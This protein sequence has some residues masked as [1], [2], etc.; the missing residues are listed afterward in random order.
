M[1]WLRIIEHLLWAKPFIYSLS[2]RARKMLHHTYTITW[3]N[4]KDIAFS[5]H[6]HI[7]SNIP[8]NALCSK[9]DY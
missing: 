5:F 6:L 9:D 3:K 7:S 8:M 4:C 2:F 1:K